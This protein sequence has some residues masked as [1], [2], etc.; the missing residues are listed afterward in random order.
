[1]ADELVNVRHTVDDAA[2]Y[3]VSSNTWRP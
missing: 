1:M 3:S 2:S